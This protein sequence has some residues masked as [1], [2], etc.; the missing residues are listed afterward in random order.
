SRPAVPSLPALPAEPVAS[1]AEPVASPEPGEPTAPAEAAPLPAM[2]AEPA[3][4]PP[5]VGKNRLLMLASHGGET[6]T[7]VRALESYGLEGEVSKEFDKHRNYLAEYQTILT[8]S[9]WFDHYAKDGNKQ[10][11]AFA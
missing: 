6:G 2:P 7:F 9:N 8:G 11:E 1:P 3:T 5:P 4:E 10:P